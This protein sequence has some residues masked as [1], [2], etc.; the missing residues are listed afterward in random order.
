MSSVETLRRSAAWLFAGRTGEQV[1]AFAF[2]I[3]LARLLAPEAFGMLLTIQV[4]TGLAGFVAG[5]GM[6]Q[7]LVRAKT[8]DKADYDIV[9]TLQL[10]I[11]LLIYLV[12]FALAPLLARWYQTP[13]YEDLLRVSALS[14]LLR[15]FLNL[16][17]S[18]LTRAM[19]FK[20]QAGVTIA[21]LVF[22]SAVSIGMAALG[23]G[24][25]SL[26]WSGLLGAALQSA[27]LTR[28][29]GWRP[30]LSRDVGRAGELARYGFLVTAND[31]VDYAKARVNVFILS[32][33]LGPAAVGL[34]NKSESLARMP[35]SF[36][37]GS[38]YQVLFRAMAAEQSNS[39]RCR[40]LYLRSVALVAVYGTP[41]YVGLLWLAE[42]LV[43]GVYGDHWTAAARPL[44]V[45]AAAWPFWL[46]AN[47]SGAV[48]AALNRLD[49]ELPIQLVNLA[50]T[51][52]LVA[53][54][55]R[56]GLEGVAWAMVL[57]S[58]ISCALMTR[59]ALEALG[60]SWRDIGLALVP[61]A[62]LNTMLAATLAA[63]EY[64]LPSG[65]LAHDLLH[66]LIVGTTGGLVYACAL[67]FIPFRG[68]H[69][70]GARIREAFRR[71]A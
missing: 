62:A 67:L 17:N 64:G 34:F 10:A 19:R 11:G 5:G 48:A 30:G 56:W 71:R 27:I 29:T 44:S 38:V 65:W 54:S 60:A 12:F 31:L 52:T 2:G 49:R 37:S 41:F 46:L 66:L 36:V 68:L 1:L 3:V 63:L 28:L 6:G 33:S 70:E 15:P 55:L 21:S 43:R 20:A 35:F 58:T 51:A 59:L 18:L 14:F 61:A 53:L 45:M 47:L 7:A 69:G 4:F 26:V 57:A 32:T 39:D 42:P 16:P 8:A 9:F 40:Y 24:V 13:L 50:V 25:W 22:S 23:C